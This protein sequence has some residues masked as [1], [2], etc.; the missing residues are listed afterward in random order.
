[1]LWLFSSLCC[2]P[3]PLWVLLGL[4]FLPTAAALSEFSPFPELTFL[5]FS[6]FIQKN[7]PDDISLSTV[8]LLLFTMTENPDLL[9]LHARQQYLL[10]KGENISTINSW[11]KSLSRA[12]HA[13][14]NNSASLL[15]E[16]DWYEGISENH[17]VSN[18]ATKLDELARH[19]GLIKYN[20]K[21]H[22]KT[23]LKPISYTAIEAVHIICPQSYQCVTSGCGFQSLVQ[24]TKQRDIPL[25]T[26]VKNN[27]IHKDVP[28]LTGRCPNCMTSYSADHERTPE[29]NEE[30][31][32]TSLY[33]NSAKF[34]KVG[35][36]VWVDQVFSNAVVNAMYSFHASASS[37]MEFW[38][39]S[40]GKTQQHEFHWLSCHQI[41][42]AFVQESTCTI[43]A[44]ADT[45]LSV[46]DNLAI[47]EI[48]KEAFSILG[49]NGV[50]RAADQHACSE[51][52]HDYIA[53]TADT[54]PTALSAAVV[55]VDEV[56][57]SSPQ[58]AD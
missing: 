10:A 4:S 53:T 14:V 39:N 34:L 25:V 35:Q 28:V 37:Y 52:T 13:K 16:S 41:W 44:S 1:M 51:C 12:V 27:T 58:P 15:H 9:S 6:Q 8:L 49:E 17:I 38:N 22:L 33:L 56:E 20:K 48:T 26:L 32:F 47:G 46:W 54:T 40:F 3:L 23:A 19:L 11:I 7:F 21:G 57:Q 2:L 42:Q 31:Q 30:N 24:T 5:S 45:E 18:I 43:A 29:I 36:S 55:G 50:I